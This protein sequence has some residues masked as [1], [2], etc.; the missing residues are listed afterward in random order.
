MRA[1]AIAPLLGAL[2]ACATPRLPAEAAERTYSRKTE[3]V[4]AAAMEAVRDMDLAVDAAEH[5][6]WGGRID[7]RRAEGHPVRIEARAA[8]ADRTTVT[9]RADGGLAE[10]LLDRISIRLGSGEPAAPF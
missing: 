7:A 1:A 9:V 6:S 4:W 10:L 8:G 5:D 2:G 3:E